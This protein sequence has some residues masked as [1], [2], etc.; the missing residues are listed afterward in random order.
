MASSAKAASQAEHSLYEAFRRL[1]S[2]SRRD[3]ALRIL[4]DEKLLSDLYDHLLI[5]KAMDEAGPG[6]EW[7]NNGREP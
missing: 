1:D 4:K 7:P 5:K 6:I 3:V 2:K